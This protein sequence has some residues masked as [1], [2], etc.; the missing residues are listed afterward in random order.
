[1]ELIYT[2]NQLIVSFAYNNFSSSLMQG[3]LV[4]C[5][6]ETSFDLHDYFE[7]VHPLILQ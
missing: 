6:E 4:I 3:A 5:S 2:Q 7:F 1:M